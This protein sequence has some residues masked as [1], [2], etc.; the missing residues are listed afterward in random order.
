MSY[1]LCF[2]ASAAASAA[3]TAA[4]KN[5]PGSLASGCDAKLHCDSASKLTQP[6]LPLQPIPSAAS[7]ASSSLF[8]GKKPRNGGYGSDN[9]GYRSSASVIGCESYLHH[10]SNNFEDIREEAEAIDEAAQ[11]QR[12]ETHSCPSSPAETDCSSGFSTLR[13]RSVTVTE[14]VRPK[15]PCEI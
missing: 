12:L 2:Q 8:R 1:T 4:S 6:Q 3:S 9:R 14:K 7:T 15:R 13:R 5:I 10:S 11:G